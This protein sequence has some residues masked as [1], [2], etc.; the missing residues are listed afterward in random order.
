MGIYEE[1]S[2]IKHLE[3]TENLDL[4]NQNEIIVGRFVGREAD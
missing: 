1:N 4:R 2:I 3:P